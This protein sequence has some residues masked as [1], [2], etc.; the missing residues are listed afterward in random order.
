MAIRIGINGFGRIGRNAARVIL[1]RPAL[2]LA[3]I[4]S[5]SDASSH[6]Y[7]FAHDSCYGSLPNKIAVDGTT[8]LTDTQRVLCFQTGKPG[9]IPWQEAAVDVV[10][11]CTGK[12]RETREA[13]EHIRDTVRA[14]VIS[15][16]VK[17]DT[18]TY[19]MG[20]NH[21]SYTGETVVSNSSC[22]TNCVASVIN[23]LHDACGV[24][25][26][27]MTTVH[28]VT[29]SQNLLD[30]SHKK[31]IRLRRSAMENIIPT[32]S[33]S[34]KDLAK[35][36]PHL[37]GLLPCRALR[38]PVP[39]VSLVDLVV[40]VKAK[41]TREKVN[42]AFEKASAKRLSGIVSVAREPLVS[43][44]YV[45]SPYSAIVDPWL[46]D[47]VDETLVHITA[48]YDN[49]WGYANRLVDLAAYIIRKRPV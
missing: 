14:V 33:G 21:S 45:G 7:L 2:T 22:T 32:S 25:R 10:L 28:A 36:F 48:W 16:P 3:A 8:L 5:N 34:A 38:V 4:N 44:D 9:D 31:D 26:G 18:P 19:V 29:D 40:Q 43:R 42:A 17:D 49:E 39:T 24:I 27:N 6:A 41:T 30:N 13:R 35:L 1:T 23:V 20:V 11:E 15:A 12:F 46:T 37:T 47:V